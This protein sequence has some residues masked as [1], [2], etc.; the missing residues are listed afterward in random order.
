MRRITAHRQVRLYFRH[1]QPICLLARYVFRIKCGVNI[2]FSS[3]N[4]SGRLYVL[5]ALLLFF[6][7]IYLTPIT[8]I[9]WTDFYHFSPNRTL[10]LADY[11][12]GP[13]SMTTNLRQ[14]WRTNFES[15]GILTFQNGLGYRNIDERLYSA[16]VRS[17]SCINLVNLG[18]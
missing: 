18:Q 4:L 9:Y 7:V 14:N 6:K 13:L 16:N 10:F 15:F 1:F 3:V 12:S 8:P 2:V 5:L 11:E 17:T